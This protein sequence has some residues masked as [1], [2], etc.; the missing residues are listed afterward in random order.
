MTATL[1]LTSPAIEELRQKIAV[2]SRILARFTLVDY[3]G[4]LSARIPGTELVLI[5]AR[6]AEQ[7]NQLH[8]KPEYVSV[9]DLDAGL[10]HGHHAPDET[11]MHTEIYRARPEVMAVVHTHQSMCTVFGDIGKPVLPM[12]GVGAHLCRADIPVYPSP[13]KITTTEQGEAVARCLGDKPWLHLRNHGVTFVAA[14][15]EQ[16]VMNAIWVEDQARLTLWG[17]TAGTPHGMSAEDAAAVEREMFGWQGRW[18]YYVSLLEDDGLSLD[19][20]PRLNRSVHAEGVSHLNPIPSAARIGNVVVT[21]SVYGIDPATG[22]I[23]PDPEQQVPYMFRNL[24]KIVTAAGATTRDIAKL[25]F[26]VASMT[27]RDAINK[28]W[29]A[30]FP[31]PEDRPARHVAQFDHLPSPAAVQCEALVVIDR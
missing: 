31:D 21:G 1:D 27:S 26:S 19:A 16:V 13:R 4:H 22:K 15:V 12:Q 25:S 29:V 5:R 2:G 6:G 14:S 20:P 8:M 9:V 7:G 18:R 30:M 17:W 28:E 10:V 24:E 23:H 3:L 11:K